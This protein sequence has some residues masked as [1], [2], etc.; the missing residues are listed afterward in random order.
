MFITLESESESESF[1]FIFL[2]FFW[3]FFKRFQALV[4]FIKTPKIEIKLNSVNIFSMFY[5]KVGQHFP[6]IGTSKW[7]NRNVEKVEL[8]EKLE[9]WKSISLS[10][11]EK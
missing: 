2:S 5:H 1:F 10:T 8:S 3:V 6:G 4:Y 9:F 7:A 11:L